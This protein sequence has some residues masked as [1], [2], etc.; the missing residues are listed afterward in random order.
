MTLQAEIIIEM[1]QAAF[2]I[3]AATGSDPDS[4]N[5]GHFGTS[6]IAGLSASCIQ[7]LL[8]ICVMNWGP[9]PGC[10]CSERRLA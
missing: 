7:K 2:D 4:G 1:S 9:R 8:D 5:S 6:D 3:H 10:E